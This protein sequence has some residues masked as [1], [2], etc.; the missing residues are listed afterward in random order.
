MVKPITGAPKKPLITHAVVAVRERKQM[1]KCYIQ[2]IG[3][4]D[5]TSL[6]ELLMLMLYVVANS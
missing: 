5:L 2:P 1:D 6:G 3:A 4:M